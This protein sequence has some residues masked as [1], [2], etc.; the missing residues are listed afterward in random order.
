MSGPVPGR[1]DRS[2]RPH[3]VA[4]SRDAPG[5]SRRCAQA[6]GRV[7]GRAS[8][9]ARR[10]ALTVA[11]RDR[12]RRA[13]LPASRRPA[14]TR[15]TGAVQ[16]A[17]VHRRSDGLPRRARI[18]ACHEGSQVRLGQRAGAGCRSGRCASASHLAADPRL[19]WRQARDERGAPPRGS[20][21]LSL[22][23]STATSGTLPSAWSVARSATPRA[24]NALPHRM[25]SG[26]KVLVHPRLAGNIAAKA[27]TPAV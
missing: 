23:P 9:P 26:T 19:R 11:L 25:A 24:H 2:R 1:C 15:A 5:G 8:H 7:R 17:R 4:A 18:G 12:R 14:A 6:A 27:S 16:G 3:A 21:S 13:G 22:F 10:A 20:A